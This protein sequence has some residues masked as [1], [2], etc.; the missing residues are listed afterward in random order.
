MFNILSRPPMYDQEAVQPMR[1]ELVAVGFTELLTPEDVDKAI[2]VK[3]D[4]TVL[5]MINSVCGCAAGSARPGV[6]LALQNEI[7]PDK[8]YTGF[9]GQ[10]RDAVDKIRQY[11]KSYPPSSPSVALFKNGELL[12]FMRR[13]DIEGF[14]AEQIADTLVKVFNKYCGAKGPSI[15][16]EQFAQVQYAKQCGSKIPLFKG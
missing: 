3:D 13:M 6:S 1:D 16:P 8:L 9:A 2:N 12:Y 15:S 7:I 14:T 10:E 11:I 5:V 4:K